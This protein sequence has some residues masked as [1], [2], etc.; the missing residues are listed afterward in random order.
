MSTYSLITKLTLDANELI[1][2]SMSVD[3][4]DADVKRFVLAPAQTIQFNGGA[5]GTLI[6]NDTAAGVKVNVT[7]KANVH[8]MFMFTFLPGDTDQ[9]TIEN[10]HTE[11]VVF[12][13]AVFR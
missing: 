13:V 9:I 4:D 11:D 7:F 6:V 5:K 1:A 10:T 8:E 3:S 12:Q 2:S